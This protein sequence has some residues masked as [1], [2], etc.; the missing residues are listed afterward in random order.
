MNRLWLKMVSLFGHGR[1]MKTENVAFKESGIAFSN[2]PYPP[3]SVYPSG[4]VTYDSVREILLS[5]APPEIRTHGGEVLF[6]SAVLKED[7]IATAKK[8]Q[9][10]MTSRVDVWS[11]ILEPFLDTE[12]DDS[13]ALSIIKANGVDVEECL[14]IRDSLA[15]AMY[16]YNIL[17]GIWDWCHLGL[18][19]AL[20]ALLANGPFPKCH[21]YA[22]PPDEYREFYLRS[23]Q[24]AE[25]GK[26]VMDKCPRCGY[27]I[28]GNIAGRC[29]ECGSS[30]I[31]DFD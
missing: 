13:I 23:M 6:V 10:P 27:D 1:R 29:P 28:S 7:L 20:D 4:F 15:S 25:C 31:H 21:Q 12:S 2:Y 22:L 18:A 17:S 30:A 9:I 14:K 24:I 8:K 26:L 5:Q 11:F 16:A 19:C 3:A